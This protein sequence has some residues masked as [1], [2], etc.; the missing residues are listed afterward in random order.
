MNNRKPWWHY[1]DLHDYQQLT[2]EINSQLQHI[3]KTHPIVGGENHLR[4]WHVP[5]SLFRII[6]TKTEIH[7][8]GDCY[9]L[10]TFTGRFYRK[11]GFIRQIRAENQVV[12]ALLFLGIVRFNSAWHRYPVPES[13]WLSELWPSCLP[14]PLP[15]SVE[16]VADGIIH[17]VFFKQTEPCKCCNFFTE[18]LNSHAPWHCWGVDVLAGAVL[19]REIQRQFTHCQAFSFVKRQQSRLDQQRG[20][21]DH[22]IQH[23]AVSTGLFKKKQRSRLTKCRFNGQSS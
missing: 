3:L 19:V 7:Q 9:R 13:F 17:L 2:T 22:H 12:L 6:T 10:R 18:R 4:T 14:N 16:R 20:G 5:R 8:S 21:H 11:P 15:D 1:T 23:H